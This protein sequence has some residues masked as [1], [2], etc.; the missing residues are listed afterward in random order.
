MTSLRE[1]EIDRATFAIL[2]QCV[3]V[4]V[5]HAYLCTNKYKRSREPAELSEISRDEYIYS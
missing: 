5:F 3:S 4:R 1:R 2:P